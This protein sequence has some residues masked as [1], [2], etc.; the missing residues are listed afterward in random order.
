MSQR[1]KLSITGFCSARVL[2][3]V[4]VFEFTNRSVRVMW[5]SMLQCGSPANDV[6]GAG[7]CFSVPQR[8]CQGSSRSSRSSPAG[9]RPWRTRPW[10]SRYRNPSQGRCTRCCTSAVCTWSGKTGKLPAAN[11]TST[12]FILGE[13]KKKICFYDNKKGAVCM[14]SRFPIADCTIIYIQ[15]IQCVQRRLTAQMPGVRI[16]QHHL[17]KKTGL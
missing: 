16:I 15:W 5:P 4:L 13:E 6:T 7:E 14:S 1:A 17:M 9:C 2:N 3:N 10:T 12:N 8:R 11:T